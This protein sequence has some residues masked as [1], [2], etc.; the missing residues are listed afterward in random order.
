MEEYKLI[1]RLEYYKNPKNPGKITGLED[2]MTTSI[3]LVMN[4]KNG[5]VAKGYDTKIHM[6]F[7]KVI[8]TKLIEQ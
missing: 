4:W 5:L 1:Y 2:R 7:Y 6:D 3:P 8:G